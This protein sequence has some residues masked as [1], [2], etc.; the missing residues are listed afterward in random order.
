VRAT[1]PDAQLLLIV[2]D[3]MRADVLAP[4]A[5]PRLA[6]FA[7]GAIRFD[8]HYS[9]GNASRAGMTPL[10]YGLPATYWDA[11]AG[12]ARP[13]VLMDLFRANGYQLGLFVATPVYRA[14]GLDRTALARIPNLRSD[15]LPPGSA[16]RELI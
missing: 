13:P 15:A 9:G 5:A 6:E 1:P 2:V 4:D 16:A 14:V 8:A 11:F 10:F 3:A 12:I 7:Q